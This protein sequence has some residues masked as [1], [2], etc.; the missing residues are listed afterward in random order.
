ME[1]YTVETGAPQLHQL[2]KL[3]HWLLQVLVI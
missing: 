3:N 1:D 2:L